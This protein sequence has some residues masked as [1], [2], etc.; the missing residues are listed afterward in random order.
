MFGRED[1]LQAE[2][3]YL[4]SRP[5][6]KL[7]IYE[8]LDYLTD[9]EIEYRIGFQ[10]VNLFLDHKYGESDKSQDHVQI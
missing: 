2:I 5:V 9:N 10:Q 8:F 1:E 6:T 4:R 7:L 3:D